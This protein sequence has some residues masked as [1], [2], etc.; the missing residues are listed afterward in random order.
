MRAVDLTIGAG[1]D[2][3]AAGPGFVPATRL[4]TGE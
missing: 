2:N 4:A 3:P 1:T